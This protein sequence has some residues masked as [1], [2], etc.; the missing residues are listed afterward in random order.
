[1]ILT[2][3]VR[4]DNKIT[5]PCPYGLKTEHDELIYIGSGSCRSCLHNGYI[6][7]LRKTI[8][9]FHSSHIDEKI[10]IPEIEK[11]TT[12]TVD[13]KDFDTLE[14]AKKEVFKKKL[15]SLILI[16]EATTG[17]TYWVDDSLVAFIYDNFDDLSKIMDNLKE[18]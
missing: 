7:Y 14:D 10:D 5:T 8:E 1:M 16:K 2:Y 13:D 12:F 15:E 3:S 6:S 11:T 4:K 9:C 17:H 18:N